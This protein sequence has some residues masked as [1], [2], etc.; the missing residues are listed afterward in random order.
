MV[1]SNP[2][3]S[4]LFP[5]KTKDIWVF[6][7]GPTASM[8]KNLITKAST[9]FAVNRCFYEKGRDGNPALN[10]IPD[11]Y[12]ALDDDTFS[13]ENEGIKALKSLRKFTKS[14]S[15][16]AKKMGLPDLRLFNVLGEFGF[17]V[18]TLDIYHG[19]TSC[20]CAL[21]LAVQMALFYFRAKDFVVHLA[22]IDLGV[23]EGEDGKIMSHQYGHG[24][25]DTTIFTR[26]L[27]SIRFGLDFMNKNRI[28]WVNHSPL[29]HNRIKDLI[30]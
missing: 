1:T 6:G 27:K 20:Y 17:S 14:T 28:K 23:L 13:L 11:Y 18:N 21:Q 16:E 24:N 26:M 10:L 30:L 29:L 3:Y 15:Q 8:T 9:V 22:G 4:D 12:V 7:D 19:K 2:D 25:Y 5:K